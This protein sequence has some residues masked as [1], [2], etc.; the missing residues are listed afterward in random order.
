MVKFC[1]YV[2]LNIV[3]LVIILF[4]NYLVNVILIGGKIMGEVF[5]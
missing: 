5:V 2:V 1:L 4:V 3:G